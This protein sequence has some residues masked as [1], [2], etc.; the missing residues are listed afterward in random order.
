VLRLLCI[1]ALILPHLA[2]SQDIGGHWKFKKSVDFE[3]PDVS[4]GATYQGVEIVANKLLLGRGCTLQLDKVK[5][6]PD[7]VFQALWRIGISD[8]SIDNF[9]KK[10]FDLNLKQ[11]TYLY[12][13]QTVGG[14]CNRLGEHLFFLQNRL[15]SIYA[16]TIFSEYVRAPSGNVIGLAGKGSDPGD[17]KKFNSE[18]SQLPFDLG[19]YYSS[20][21]VMPKEMPSK[22]CGPIFVPH[23]ASQGG[24]RL[25][26]LIATHNYK[27]MGREEDPEDYSNPSRNKLHPVYLVFPPIGAITIVRVDDFEGE[28]EA[29]ELFGGAYLSIKNGKIVDQLNESCSLDAHYVCRSEDHREFR[30][31]P[32]GTFK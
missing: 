19:K 4:R 28:N 15:I 2:F 26:A 25:S 29:R 20:C 17:I 10:N 1:V 16:G 23:I 3:S 5:Y 30:L 31:T 22:Y 6:S 7:L 14:R 32:E 11:I 18:F 8:D 24:S 9:L 27:H 21:A 12:V 13:A